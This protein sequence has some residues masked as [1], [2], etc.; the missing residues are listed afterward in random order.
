MFLLAS[1]IQMMAL[2]HTQYVIAEASAPGTGANTGQVKTVSERWAMCS[3]VLAVALHVTE[4]ESYYFVF[5]F[6]MSF[7]YFVAR[8]SSSQPEACCA[9]KCIPVV[10]VLKRL[11]THKIN[12]A[13]FCTYLGMNV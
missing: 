8:Q 3:F 10:A 13:S 7:F 11:H 9:L 12:Q 1:E 5:C 4:A 2:P 6:R